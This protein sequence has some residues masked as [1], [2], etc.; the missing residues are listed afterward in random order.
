MLVSEVTTLNRQA[1]PE[2]VSLL[3]G[4]FDLVFEKRTAD[5]A[6][7]LRKARNT[8]PEDFKK[9][10]KPRSYALSD[11][12]LI[13]FVDRA[14]EIQNETLGTNDHAVKSFGVQQLKGIVIGDELFLV[15]D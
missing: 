2:F 7:A 8:K 3:E 6:I 15:V 4:D 10:A 9:D 11:Y 13:P 5:N 1:V 12:D 14:V